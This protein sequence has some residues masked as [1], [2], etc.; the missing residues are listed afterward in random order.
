MN[1]YI[2]KLWDTIVYIRPNG[3]LENLAIEKL[4]IKKY[5]ARYLKIAFLHCIPWDFKSDYIN[6]FNFLNPRYPMEFLF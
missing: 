2:L 1:I 6:L 4:A 3:N 5:T